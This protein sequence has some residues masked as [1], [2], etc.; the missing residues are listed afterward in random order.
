MPEVDVIVV[1]N[2]K[3]ILETGT[4]KEL[5]EKKGAFSDFILTHLQE[6]DDEDEDDGNLIFK[7]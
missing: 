4:Y 3:T 5:M 1:L 7:C 2:D 6:I